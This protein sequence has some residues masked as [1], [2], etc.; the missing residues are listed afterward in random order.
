M[1][2]PC[3]P[4]GMAAAGQA[5]P[6]REISGVFLGGIQP[7]ARHL[8]RRE[9]RPLRAWRAVDVPVQPGVIHQDLQAAANQQDHQHEIRVVRHTQPA[10]KP[11]APAA[12]SRARGG[13]AGKAGMP[14]SPHCAYAAISAAAIR[15]TNGRSV[16][17]RTCTG[18]HVRQ[19]DGDG[20]AGAGV[21]GRAG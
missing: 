13:T 14:A 2:V 19:R 9:S 21:D 18:I 10:A 6:G 4:Q 11:C 3:Q 20:I 17:R 7:V 12:V 15:I 16:E 5:D 8:H 1:P